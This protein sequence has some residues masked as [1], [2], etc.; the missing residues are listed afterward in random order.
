MV[1]KDKLNAAFKLMRKAGI[2]ARQN[3]TC[4]GSCGNAEMSMMLAKMPE[5]RSAKI[6]GVCFYHSQGNSRMNK[7]GD[8]YLQ[9]SSKVDDDLDLGTVQIGHLVVSCLK[10][11]GLGVEWNGK[12][13]ETILV[14]AGYDDTL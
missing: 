10:E 7:G 8:L 14:K 9:Y 11:A 6:K 5:K 3:F 12:A 13:S 4:C 1:N 2:L